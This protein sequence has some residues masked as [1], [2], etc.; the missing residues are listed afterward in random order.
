MLG[1]LIMVKLKN[2]LLERIVLDIK[3]GDVILGGRFKNK[4]IVV[5]SIGKDEHGMPTING[6][7][8]VNFRIAPKTE[9]NER[10]DFHDT[11]KQ[12]VNKA[13]LKSKIVF[14]KRAGNK[15][16]YNVDTDTIYITPTSDFKDFL[17]TVFHEIDHAIDA[18]KFGKK[19]Y[20]QRYEMEMNKA[21]ERGGDAHDDNYFE[22]KAEK[23][24]R[25]MA[26][27]YLRINR[28][29]IYK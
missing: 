4:K 3:P 29:N 20:K 5:K 13:G 23:F 8:V 9:V 14:A 24:G 27:D 10:V 7:K 11:A 21:V 1:W 15:A 18:K 26:K 25:K 28:K 12:I 6:R 16:D 2:L 19:K 22:K 17:V